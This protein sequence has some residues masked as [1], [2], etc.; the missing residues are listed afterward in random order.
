MAGDKVRRN[1]RLGR[2]AG[3]RLGKVLEA[4]DLGSFCD[5][6]GFNYSYR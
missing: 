1:E 6:T 2:K 4:K 5:M 3:A